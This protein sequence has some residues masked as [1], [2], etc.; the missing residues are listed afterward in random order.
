[1]MPNFRLRELSSQQ[2]V[3]GDVA[4]DHKRL[5]PGDKKTSLASGVS[6]SLPRT[7]GQEQAT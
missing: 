3:K 6:E 5:I 2:A 4:V 1:M 7:V